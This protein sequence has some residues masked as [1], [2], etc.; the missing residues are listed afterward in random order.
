[1]PLCKVS[2]VFCVYWRTSLDLDQDDPM[3]NALMISL[4]RLGIC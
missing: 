2:P 1:M 3:A 4:S